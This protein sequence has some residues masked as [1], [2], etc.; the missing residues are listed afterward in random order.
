MAETTEAKKTSRMSSMSMKSWFLLLIV[1]GSLGAA[2]YFWQDAQD[3]RENSP[4]AVAARNEEESNRVIGALNSILLTESEDAPTVARIENPQVL[5][6]ANAD[7]YKNAQEGDYLV[8]YPQRAIIYREAEDRIIN[9]APIINTS[10]LPTPGEAID[11][12]G[13]EGNA[14]TD[15]E[16]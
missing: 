6:D 1:V 4:E 2:V 5:I 8:L 12:T 3:A 7:F 11:T 13:T 14:G 9:V 16:Q 10:Q 15:D